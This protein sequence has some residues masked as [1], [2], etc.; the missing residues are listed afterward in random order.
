MEQ[1][2]RAQDAWWDVTSLCII[3]KADLEMANILAFDTDLMYLATKIKLDMS[4]TTTLADTIAKIQD[5][6]LSAGSISTFWTMATK[7]TKNTQKGKR[8][9]INN[10]IASMMTNTELVSSALML[11]EQDLGFLLTCFMQAMQV[12]NQTNISPTESTGNQKAS[13]QK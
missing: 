9:K 2:K 4:S 12:Q 7:A 6:L 11:T 8:V 10:P 1:S 13:S 5:D 3:T